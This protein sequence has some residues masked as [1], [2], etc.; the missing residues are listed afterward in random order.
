MKKMSKKTFAIV[1][2][3]V[4]AVTICANSI[5]SLFDIPGK[6]FICDAVQAVGMAV[7]AVCACFIDQDTK[8]IKK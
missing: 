5:I 4:G 7:I 8:L 1:S 2:G 6:T 3:I